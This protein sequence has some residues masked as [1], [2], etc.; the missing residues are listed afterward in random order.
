MNYML[1]VCNDGIEASDAEEK[2]V[3]EAIG[4]RVDASAEVTVY[5]H[6]LQGPADART[7]RV[8]GGQTLVTD[9]PFVETKE[10]I[11]GFELLD[12]ETLEQAIEAAASHP[13]AWFNKIEIRPL[14]DDPGWSPEARKRL[15]R[16]VA[17]G[18][19]RYMLLICSD[20]VPTDLKRE[21]MQRELPRWV[22]RMTASGTL[23]AGSQLAGPDTASTVRVRGPHTLVS[24]G[25]FVETKEFL[26]GFDV[27]ESVDLQEAIEIA[28]AHPVAWFH[29]IEV[30][31]FTP[32]MCG[33]PELG[34]TTE[35]ATT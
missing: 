4:E 20:G 6:P 8:R 16:G 35:L 32:G 2:L 22:E 34:L 3:M 15:G 10:H 25:P 24:D 18:K 33:E 13:L 5:G 1:L 7:V 29:T 21:T 30:R 23:I 31:P 12:C 11:G 14:A 26:A 28:A 19:Q 9:G 17:A 27:I